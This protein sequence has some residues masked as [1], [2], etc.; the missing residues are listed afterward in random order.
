MC[1]N[2]KPKTINL[3]LLKTIKKFRKL[4]KQ[5]NKTKFRY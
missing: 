4:V 1:T 3:K 5:K 2:R